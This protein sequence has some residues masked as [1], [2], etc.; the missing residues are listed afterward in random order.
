MSH[1]VSMHVLGVSTSQLKGGA[2]AL[3][4]AEDK[5]RRSI[6]VVIGAAEAQS[7]AIALEGIPTPRP[8]THDLFVTFAHAFGIR[9][10]E[11]FIYAFEDGIF[12]SQLTFSDNSGQTVVVDARTSDAVAIAMRTETPIY[13]TEEILRETGFVIHDDT[14]MPAAGDDSVDNG[15]PEDDGDDAPAAPR[16]S[17]H[18]E[19]RPENMTVEE[20]ERTLQQLIDSE[21]YEEAARISEILNNKKKARGDDGAS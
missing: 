5:G 17:Y 12:S 20:L 9:L 18:A 4:L 21:N 8:L 15:T 7:I 14:I 11:V 1:K 6:P 13:T 10:R 16:G 3:I 19:P 2:Y